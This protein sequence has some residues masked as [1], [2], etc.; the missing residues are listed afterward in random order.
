MVTCGPNNQPGGPSKATYGL[1]PATE[2]LKRA[3]KNDIS[4]VS[5]SNCP[6]EGAEPVSWHY[7]QTPNDAAGLMACGTYNGRSNL[8]WTNEEKLMLSDVSGDATTIADLPT[9][10]DNYG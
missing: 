5:L 1:Y 9:W 7:D 6:G 2:T 3:F 10:W 8:I 4:N